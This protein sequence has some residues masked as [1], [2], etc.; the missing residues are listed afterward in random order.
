MQLLRVFE[1][2]DDPVDFS[3]YSLSNYNKFKSL[4][5]S[6]VF[7]VMLNLDAA[8]DDLYARV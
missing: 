2:L 8:I 5:Q 6:H 4:T 7:H 3:L 1:A